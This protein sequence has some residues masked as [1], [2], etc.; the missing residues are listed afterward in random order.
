MSGA[1]TGLKILDFSTLLPGPF[2]T[3]SFAD[4]GADVL[5]VT[6]GSRPD[7]VEIIPPYVPGTKFSATSAQIGRN[8]K[9]ITLNLKTSQAVEIVYKLVQKYDI[10]L[11]Q[12][13]PGVMK[14]LGLDYEILAKINPR[15]I[16]CSLTGYGQTGSMVNKA[17]HDI[18]YL[19][20][21]GMMGY[22]GTKEQGPSLMGIQI[23]DV[24]S[25]ACNTMISILAAV[26]YRNNTGKGQYL[27]VAMTDGAFAFNAM[28]GAGCLL[29][30]KDPKRAGEIV[31]GG[32]IYDFYET[33]DEKYISFG[34]AE[35][36]FF[37]AFCKTIGK[38]EWIPLGIQAGDEVKAEVR[39]II[40]SK[41][42]DE[43][44]NL[45]DSIDACFE[46]VLSLTE[47]LNS[48]LAKERE[49]VVEVPYD[50]GTMLKQIGSPYK[51]SESP[52]E[53]RHAGR[54]LNKADTKEVMLGLGYDAQQIQKLTDEGIFK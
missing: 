6:S 33:K 48:K 35:P 37:S 16:Y 38:E 26:I 3:M 30:G 15:L 36:Q 46:P 10:I 25:G 42:R 14:K 13:R 19:A 41:T 20:L 22:S 53:F 32:S 29:T 1:L 9:T 12:F 2:A 45:F 21:S 17:G 5:R 4:M 50:D 31:N 40:K 18:N 24:A 34:G 52:V 7:L 27:D 8:K 54:M 43:W 44:T 49:L 11:E 51:F 47:A 39:H 23:A 28:S